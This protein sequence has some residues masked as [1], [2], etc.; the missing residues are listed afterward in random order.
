MPRYC[1]R[2]LKNAM[3]MFF[4]FLGCISMWKAYEAYLSVPKWYWNS[5]GFLDM[6][7]IGEFVAWLFLVGV[8]LFALLELALFVP[9]EEGS[10]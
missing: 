2:L 4:I 1:H 8:S 7:I 6:S 5:F 10:A 3:H 9:S